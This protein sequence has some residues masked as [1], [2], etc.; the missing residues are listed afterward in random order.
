MIK[1]Q[2][3]DKIS[4]RTGI[5]KEAVKLTV[6][7][8]MECIMESVVKGE[9]VSLRRFGSF[10]VKRKPKKN[11]HAAPGKWILIPEHN[12]PCF[13]PCDEFKELVKKNVK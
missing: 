12:E 7:A 2:I 3:V 10:I 11:F 13:K 8:F 6:E 9:D 1:V 4:K 5:N